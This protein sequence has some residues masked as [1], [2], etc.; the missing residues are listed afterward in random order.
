MGG[1]GA[2]G[3]A[4]PGRRAR[5]LPAREAAAMTPTGRPSPSGTP[6]P[7]G[8]FKGLFP[9]AWKRVSEQPQVPG[10]RFKEPIVLAAG[11]PRGAR[12]VAGRVAATGRKLLSAGLARRLPSGSPRRPAGAPPGC[13]RHLLLPR[14]GAL[15]G[16]LSASAVRRADDPRGGDYRL[17]R[18]CRCRGRGLPPRYCGES[19]ATTLRLDGRRAPTRSARARSTRAACAGRSARWTRHGGPARRLLAG[20]DTPTR[21][22]LAAATLAG[23]AIAAPA[24]PWPPPRPARP[25]PRPTARWR[26]R[27]SAPARHMGAAAEAA[28]ANDGAAYADAASAVSKAQSAVRRALDGFKQL[29][30]VFT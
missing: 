15:E 21:R 8:R 14:A 9:A 29:G 2:A 18:P 10:V 1:I 4:R 25:T 23:K 20:A 19:V 13:S 16:D 26:P 12:L 27:S 22:P 28:R 11:K 30:Y 3:G 7:P 6:R 17:H 5:R 24:R